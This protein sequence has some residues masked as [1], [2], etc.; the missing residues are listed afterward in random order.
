M[1][2]RIILVIVLAAALLATSISALN[3][4]AV[5]AQAII[6]PDDFPSIQQAINAAQPGSTVYVKA[7]TY[8]ENLIVNKSI[9]L[10]GEAEESTIISGNGS[11]VIQ[12]EADDITVENLTIR[13]GGFTYN[14]NSGVISTGHSNNSILND[15]FLNELVSI[16]LNDSNNNTI[17]G[18]TIVGA[19]QW[20]YIQLE[21]SNDNIVRDNSIINNLGSGIYLSSSNG[22]LI[23]GNSVTGAENSINFEV[24]IELESSLN[25]TIQ[26]N[27]VKY[28]RS[29]G[30]MASASTGDIVDNFVSSNNFGIYSDLSSIT[31]SQNIIFNNTLGVLD[32]SGPSDLIFNNSFIQNHQQISTTLAD[33]HAQLDAGYPLGGNF[34]DDYNGTDYF[35]GPYQNETGSDGI[36]DTPYSVDGFVD[37]YPLYLPPLPSAEISAQAPLYEFYEILLG[38]Y[39]ALVTYYNELSLNLTKQIENA[40]SAKSHSEAEL[41]TTEQITYALLIVTIGLSAAVAILV[42]RTRKHPVSKDPSA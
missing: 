4:Q 5:K 1:N 8:V 22:N 38:K 35:S 24:G 28:N 16:Y 36:G 31:M 2:M 39:D 30:I 10:M 33:G 20:Y 6:V 21:N 19:T 26:N 42:V 41:G 23:D 25:D 14:T 15:I 7:G 18:N 9:T 11:T 29:Y 13:D 32:S 37:R 17:A 40:T 12:L 27:I 3:F 34:W